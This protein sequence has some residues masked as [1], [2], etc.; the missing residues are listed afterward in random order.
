MD[1]IK[2]LHRT[3]LR[4]WCLSRGESYYSVTSGG[5]LFLG[6]TDI[7]A[8][9]LERVQAFKRAAA[10][11][12]HLTN[13]VVFSPG[14][15]ISTSDAFLISEGLTHRDYD[16]DLFLTDF[17]VRREG[18][19]YW[20]NL[21]DAARLV[22][23]PCVFLGGSTNFGHFIFEYLSRLS[24]ICRVGTIENLPLV[25]YDDV[26]ERF[27][28]FLDLAGI[29]ESRRIYIPR[30]VPVAFKSLWMPSCAVYRDSVGQLNVWPEGLF[31]LRALVTRDYQ[32]PVG[33]ERARLY[34]SRASA[35]SKRVVNESQI[36]ALLAN[37]GF[38]IVNPA[39][40]S[41]V[42]QVKLVANAEV[43][44][45]PL[46]AAAAVTLFAPDDCIIIE[47]VGDGT[48]FGAYNSIVSARVTGRPYHRI[49]GQR[50]Y[51]ADNERREAI[52]ADFD[53]DINEC[54]R[55]LSAVLDLLA[56]R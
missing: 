37:N 31:S 27:R 54:K 4:N 20:L 9:K 19:R 28:E 3:S 44:W 21:G 29:D 16:I 11:C 36:A 10:F 23:A 45:C 24:V 30:D 42:E 55:V 34:F 26:P 46:G 17:L 12:G 41:A 35:D 43:I 13:C 7:F 52:Y 40:L 38:R 1:R 49:I 32:Q 25:L 47:M 5:Q 39:A 8:G 56:S 51:L 6:E 48:V 33:A 22:E 18:E 50:R 2:S 53:V 15:L 14:G